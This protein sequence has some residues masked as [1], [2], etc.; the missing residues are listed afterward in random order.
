MSKG[1]SWGRAM[2]LSMV[3]VAL[4][5]FASAAQADVEDCNGNEIPDAC[6]VNTLT[7]QE[8]AF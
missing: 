8:A 4:G 1:K 2:R 7:C 3:A 6:D 5:C